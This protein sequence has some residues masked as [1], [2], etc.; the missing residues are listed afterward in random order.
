MHS[1]D[2]PSFVY[3]I[4]RTPCIIVAQMTK[5]AY[6]LNIKENKLKT[7]IFALYGI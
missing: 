2:L 1:R 3:N 7:N 5:N 4:E 6:D